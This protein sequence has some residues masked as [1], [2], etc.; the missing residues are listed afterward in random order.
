MVRILLQHRA[1]W[2][3][4]GR[5]WGLVGGARYTR[6][7][8]VQTALREAAEEAG[9][10]AARVRV[11]HASTDDHGGWAYTT[12]YADTAIPLPVA[13]NREGAAVE[14]VA[15]DQV[16][17]R[18]LHPGFADR[19]P[20]LRLPVGVVLVDAANV[21]G[22]RPDGWWR[23]RIGAASRLLASLERLRGAV[24]PGPD[25]AL[26]VVAGA[27]AVLEGRANDATAPQWVE[28]VR[29]PRGA[30]L[31]GDDQIVDTA[32]RLVASGSS[33]VAVTADRGLRSRLAQLGGGGAAAPTAAGP[34]WLLD[35]IAGAGSPA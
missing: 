15:V 13:P 1:A 31:S 4:H 16:A 9:V 29:T 20:A 11:R 3:H 25:G 8:P 23:D 18:P 6:E 30:A 24:V 14:W 33:V 28:V 21:V 17:G 27:V 34:R 5:T 35:L 7:N 19:W 22:S 12:V 2:T 10:A 26:M 32:D